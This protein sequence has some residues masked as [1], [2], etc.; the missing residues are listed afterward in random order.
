MVVKDRGGV[1]GLFVLVILLGF[2]KN[3]EALAHA[4]T[5]L[6]N[7]GTNEN[8]TLDGAQWVGDS[9]PNKNI[10]ISTSHTIEAAISS[11]DGNP[12]YESLYRT[13][14]IF[15]EP[16]NY[17]IHGAPGNYF[18]RLHFYPFKILNFD[19]DQ[20]Y[21]GVETCCFTLA[22]SLN[23]P[24]A[25]SQKNAHASGRNSSFI[26]LVK[27]YYIPVQ[28]N[29]TVITFL[30]DKG[31]FGFINA[32]EIVQVFDKLFVDSVKQVGGNGADVGLDLQNRGIETMYRL[33]IGGTM[34][35]RDQDSSF[36]RKWEEDWSYMINPD[37]GTQLRN[38]SR[39]TYASPNDT[40]L[41]P[42]VVYETAKTMTNITLVVMRFFN[43]SWRLPV[44]P[45]FDYLIRLH[46]CELVYDKSSQRIFRIYVNNKTAAENV[47]I[48]TKAGGRD[49][50]YHEDYVDAMTSN[51]NNLWVQLGP[52]AAS[53]DQ[54]SDAALNGLEIFKLSR[55]GN[56]GYVPNLGDESN[57]KSNVRFWL[58]IVFGIVAIAG[59]GW[60]IIC[61]C[62]KKRTKDVKGK[63]SCGRSGKRFT[64]ADL[65]AATNNFD[66][67]LVIGVGGFGKV[68]KGELN[69]GILAAIKRS[70]PQSQQGLLEFE[71]EIELLSKL[72]HRHLV[73]MIG[74]CDEQ[75]EMILIYE[76]MSNGTLRS[77]LFGGDL[78]SLSWKQRLE[79]CIGAARGLYYLHT[80][81]EGGII[82][83]DVKTTNILL[84][85]RFVAKMSDFGLSK[86]GPSLEHTH[87]STA[88][89]GSFGYLDPE[90][91]MKQRLTAKSDVYSFGVVMFEVVCAR[92]VIN[93]SL[94]LEQINL[95]EWAMVCQ[96]KGILETIIDPS[97]RGNYSPK[98][99]KSFAEIAEKC[100]ADEGVARPT[101][102][103]LLC[104]LEYALQ[105]QDSWLNPNDAG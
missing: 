55:D 88:V 27:E 34:I 85:G 103:E 11:I 37:A 61:V 30:P 62:K 84:D 29:S 50:A 56:L 77:H 6:I 40:S 96:K 26:A 67:S 16:L 10:T 19:P 72:R 46:F 93:S 82:H 1:L 54:G 87:V 98:S 32:I 63:K 24:Y 45:S 92:A 94:P 3:G 22:S 66:D 70:N 75:N 80:G 81:S 97:L 59:I 42:L 8:V 51:S 86:S 65:K 104:H 39:I 33:N 13:A 105:L 4:H 20:S 100:L 95:A 47:D 15:S 35:K 28:T 7:C 44:D 102:G 9:A 76:Y 41:A 38:T 48:F 60:L 58:G 101:M 52:E 79:I 83:R 5:L 90:Y 74:F 53:I 57:G 21:F 91:F 12:A 18:L 78:P 69:D 31:S 17:T 23:V 89:K 71:T 49:K 64:L 73:S 99:L 14:R 36:R 25:I 43:M 2:V 68:Y